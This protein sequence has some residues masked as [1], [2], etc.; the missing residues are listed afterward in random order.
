MDFN[1][2]LV[3]SVFWRAGSGSPRV[4]GVESEPWEARRGPNRGQL[5]P[6]I[7]QNLQS[8]KLYKFRTLE[9]RALDSYLEHKFRRSSDCLIFK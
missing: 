6:K 4:E 9:Y 5:D 1:Y 2:F 3:E 7:D 8:K